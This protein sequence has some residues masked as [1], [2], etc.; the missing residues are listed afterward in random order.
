MDADL[1]KRALADISAETDP[2]LKSAKMA[3][4]CSALFGEHGIELVV[5]GGSGIELLTDG[6][7]ASGDLD[8]CHTGTAISPRL[9]HEIMGLLGGTGG[10]RNWLVAGMYVDI[11]GAVESFAH[12]PRRVLTGP[13]GPIKVIQAEDLFVERVLGS[14]YPQDNQVARNCARVLAA[15]ALRGQLGMDWSE[16]ARVAQ[17][18]EY[19]NLEECKTLLREVANELKLK[20]PLDPN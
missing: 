7:Y 11:L 12:T 16:V 14:F 8:L 2:T 10:P 4:L 9:R 13:Y 3:S 17:L 20:S 15:V 1:I 19:R 5:V 6:A 18:P